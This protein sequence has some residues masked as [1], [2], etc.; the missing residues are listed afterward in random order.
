M[1]WIRATIQ[2]F[3]PYTNF[4]SENNGRSSS[5]SSGKSSNNNNKN[6]NKSAGSIRKLGLASFS[7]VVSCFCCCFVSCFRGAR[8]SAPTRI[9]SAQFEIQSA[10]HKHTYSQRLRRLS[11]KHIY[12]ALNS[13]YQSI[14]LLSLFITLL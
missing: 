6:N 2:N 8:Y 3:V 7:L 9:G 11:C 1:K 13:H 4:R 14:R 10:S 12:L 5:N